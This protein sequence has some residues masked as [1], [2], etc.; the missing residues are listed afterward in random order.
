[1][2]VLQSIDRNMIRKTFLREGYKAV[3]VRK[4]RYSF[5]IEVIIFLPMMQHE[6]IVNGNIICLTMKEISML[7]TQSH[8]KDD[9]PACERNRV[10][11]K[12]AIEIVNTMSNSYPQYNKKIAVYLKEV[13]K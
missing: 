4:G 9:C 6:R 13:G 11:Y 3:K 7:T 8:C 1:M 10:A 2:I 12:K 5:S